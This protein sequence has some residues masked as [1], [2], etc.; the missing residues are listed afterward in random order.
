MGRGI[1]TLGLLGGLVL[2]PV[3]WGQEPETPA[4]DTDR[5]DSDAVLA[6][7]VELDVERTLLE[8][9]LLRYESL[10]GRRERLFAR[11]TALYGAL[12]EAVRSVETTGRE[13][14]DA[15]LDQIDALEGE[16]AKM[17]LRER[18][19]IDG[20]M[21]HGRRI[22][23]LE[24]RLAELQ[25]MRRE[26]TGALSG[27]WDVVLMPE[28]QKGAFD[29]TQ[30]GTLVTG[31]YRLAGGWTGSL[32]GTLVAR[33]VY[34]VRIDSQLGK[35]MELEGFLSSDGRTIRGTWLTYAL[36]SGQASSGQWS[37]TKR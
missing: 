15:L 29:F 35:S 28:G 3:L 20:I 23:L 7:A 27:A 32:Q 11:L 5:A 18:A 17:L 25:G 21:T 36:A 26:E 34:L 16:R 8:E 10:A 22:A 33:K 19:L 14:G 30:N 13:R 24:E 1:M 4:V 2:A 31:T 9:E 12:D 6:V 37:A